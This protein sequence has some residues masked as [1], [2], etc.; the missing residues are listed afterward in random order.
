VEPTDWFRIR[1]REPF[2]EEAVAAF[3][4]SCAVYRAKMEAILQHWDGLPTVRTTPKPEVT[5]FEP[6][7]SADRRTMS[8][9]IRVER[10]TLGSRSL[11]QS[12]ASRELYAYLPFPV[13]QGIEVGLTEPALDG[14]GWR[15]DWWDPHRDNS[16][17]PEEA[18]R[19]LG[20][21]VKP[22]PEH[23]GRAYAVPGWRRRLQW[24]VSGLGQKWRGRRT[25]R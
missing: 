17:G 2:S 15:N 25:R 9:P 18:F 11:F 22:D 7:V 1:H 5:F 3:R 21:R 13:I 19:M 12:T 16:I 8:L 6:E 10:M 24:F 4:A 20:F 14:P 23:P